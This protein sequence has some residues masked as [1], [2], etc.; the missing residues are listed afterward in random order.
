MGRDVLSES[1]LLSEVCRIRLEQPRI[2]CRKLHHMLV[3]RL[4]A[5]MVPG[6]DKLFG[7]LRREGMLVRMRRSSRPVTTMSWHRFHKYPNTYM[8]RM[9]RSPNEVWV[10]DITYIRMSGDGF[11]YLSLITD[12]Y[13]H[14]IVGWA[15]SPSLSMDGP[16]EALSMALESLPQ[17]HCLT[18]HSDRG[19]QYCSDKYVSTL[20][21]RH[22]GISM[23]ENGD[24]L[25]NAVAERVNGILKTEWPELQQ[26]TSEEQA[27][28]VTARV[29]GT[30]NC[31]RPHLSVGYLTPEQ[32]H[33]T[34]GMSERKWKTYYKKKG[35]IMT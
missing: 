30:Y 29:I 27:R 23:T 3:S 35:E 15:L 10:S 26:C 31:R 14:K 6:R 34:N 2:G 25:E 17:K 1:L 7:I 33:R 21:K 8:N 28:E 13:S 19:V 11:M 24:P 4:P 32:A 5:G 22:V 18:H 20:R 12:A 16:L 9:P